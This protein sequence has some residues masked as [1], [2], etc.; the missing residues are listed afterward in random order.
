MAINILEFNGQSQVFSSVKLKES[1]ESIF[2]SPDYD[3]HIS[4]L[5]NFPLALSPQSNLD[6]LVF[7][8]A[9]QNSAPAKLNILNNKEFFNIII[10]IKIANINASKTFADGDFDEEF[11]RDCFDADTQNID[12]K[13]KDYL[14]QKCAFKSV[15]LEPLIFIESSKFF[16]MK[17]ILFASE[18]TLDTIFKYL[19]HLKYN[20]FSSYYSWESSGFD[21]FNYDIKRVVDKASKDSEFGF[22]TKKKLDYIARKRKTSDDILDELGTKLLIIDGKAGTGKTLEL[23]NISSRQI[24]SGKNILFLT[25]N[26]LLVN[27]VAKTLKHRQNALLI[28]RENNNL[29]QNEEQYLKVGEVSVSTIHYYIFHLVKSMGIVLIINQERVRELL[30]N[31]ETR[32]FKIYQFLSNNINPAHSIDFPMLMALIQ[33][34]TDL[35]IEVKEQGVL[36]LNFLK[37]KGY[38]PYWN[39]RKNIDYFI[40]D[41]TKL[42]LNQIQNDAF[43][44]DY[45]NILME[46]LKAMN[47]SDDFYDEHQVESMGNILLKHYKLKQSSDQSFTKENFSQ[48]ISKRISTRLRGR[49]VFID[50][51][52]DCTQIER[53]ILIRIFKSPNFVIS[54]GGKE[55]LIRTNEVLDWTISAGRK[56]PSKTFKKTTKT[57]RMK[58]NIVHLVNYVANKFQ[59]HLNL[60]PDS[61]ED[62]GEVIFD[63]RQ[64]S[65]KNFNE[66]I[67]QKYST[68]LINGYS[69]YE[70]LLFLLDSRSDHSYQEDKEKF[71]LVI[72]ES[73]NISESK[74]FRRNWIYTDSIKNNDQFNLWNG[75]GEGKNN[76][77][78][79]Q[80]L[81]AR[82]IYYESCRGL[83]AFSV[84]CFALDKYF[85]NKTK[86]DAASL[87]L[88]DDLYAT[89]LFRKNTYAITAVLMAL[90]RAIDSLYI[91]I[92]EEDSVLGKIFLE[93]AAQFPEKVRLFK[94]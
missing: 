30:E 2:N 93:Y 52:H 91:N 27:D 20:K 76:L 29:I 59:I 92:I 35:S 54:S 45:H 23:I 13:I 7:I 62:T 43:L 94:S 26:N 89:D 63:F 32:S 58:S 60:T 19:A 80:N 9:N 1:V 33:N 81:D 16:V 65:G 24:E 72:T 57:Y 25:Y 87:Y 84:F 8:K 44:A 5:N 61:D 55:Q 68:G 41:R 18:L 66:F 79:P 83:E 50:E 21:T 85:D 78:I 53:D 28:Q 69:P 75:T 56:H 37:R 86:D 42:L 82:M 67:S 47:N 36:I 11:I 88:L 17:N 90:T 39:L 31:L 49:T 6:I 48:R 34:S 3:V 51:A 77:P 73:S 46:T 10:P 15:R 40:E 14:E 38:K 64:S 22:L 4:V 71:K 74:E 12:K 70:S